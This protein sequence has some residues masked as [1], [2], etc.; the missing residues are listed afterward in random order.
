MTVLATVSG[1]DLLAT[2]TGDFEIGDFSATPP[3][4]NPLLTSLPDFATLKTI[5][6]DLGGDLIFV[7]NGDLTSLPPFVALTG[8]TDSI[9]IWN[10]ASLT[11][12]SGFSNLATVGNDITIRSN[13]ALETISG[14][15][16]LMSIGE[17]FQIEDNAALT[18][19][20]G[21]G[22]ITTI[23]NDFTVS[24][25][26]VLSS[27]CGLLRLVDDTVMPGGDITNAGNA[28]GCASTDEIKA[29]CAPYTD[30]NL[31]IDDNIF[32]PNNVAEVTRITGD[33]TISGKGYCYPQFC[34]FEDCG[35]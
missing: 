8:V 16:A 13:D 14:F 11:T 6:G 22:M 26:A 2:I 15:G 21:F 23:G 32:V 5:G 31:A 35:G 25:N 7:E 3:T 10:N 19:V 1:F 20:S 27:C 28:K 34:C 4:G 18:T 24:D 17:D 29:T 12:V 30:G 33:L 9:F